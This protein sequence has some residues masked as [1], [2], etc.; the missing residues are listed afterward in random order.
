MVDWKTADTVLPTA[1]AR[2]KNRRHF[3]DARRHP[4]CV[5]ANSPC[6]RRLLKA[7]QM[8]YFYDSPIFEICQ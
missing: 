5:A 6:L 7:E 1:S 4:V 3:P 8:F 2:N